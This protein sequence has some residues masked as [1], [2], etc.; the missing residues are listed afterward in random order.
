MAEWFEDWFSSDEY[1]TVYK[2]RDDY[3]AKLLI[4]L[5]CGNND[6]KNIS[7]VLDLACGAG[8][9]S[10]L[11][12]EKGFSVTG[13]DLSQNLLS[14]AKGKS[15]AL[16]LNIEFLKGDLRNF[17]I[18]KKFEMVV[19]LFT[20]FGYFI[21]DEDNFNVFKIAYR[22]LAPNGVFVFDF[23]NSEYV[24]NNLNK[25]N[26]EDVDKYR[27]TQNRR[28]T[29]GRVVK[30][31]NITGPGKKRKFFESVRL[32]ESETL[33]KKIE[34]IGFKIEKCFG[35][36]TGEQFNKSDSQRFIIFAKK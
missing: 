16:G 19:N 10:I 23:L 17:E 25:Y 8:R 26:A 34:S 11:L 4:D 18:D 32:Y 13:V 12:A 24:R 15:R 35:S 20:S 30:E 5:I 2:H 6:V 27:I 9:H 7:T 3:D 31:I 36:Y 33:I 14:I 29:D 21:T 28:I 22:Q 1:L